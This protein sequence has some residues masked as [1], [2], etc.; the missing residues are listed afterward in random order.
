MAGF[1][2]MRVGKGGAFQ[3]ALSTTNLYRSGNT[4]TI[5]TGSVSATFTGGTAPYVSSWSVVSGDGITSVNPTLPSTAF[6]RINTIPNDSY[7]G[8]A[9]LNVTDAL[10]KTAQSSIVYVQIDRVL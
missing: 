9:T 10:G 1:A 2:P 4:S 5:T 3:I 6:R 7:F 8:E